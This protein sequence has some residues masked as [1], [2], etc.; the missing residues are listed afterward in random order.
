M[1]FQAAAGISTLHNLRQKL[2]SEAYALWG[3]RRRGEAA[4]YAGLKRC[5]EAEATLREVGV[6]AH[7]WQTAK[8]ALDTAVTAAE[9]SQTAYRNAETRRERLERIRRVAPFLSD[10]RIAQV[11]R[12]HL[13]TPAAL[14]P[15]AAK[16]FD[17]AEAEIA[18]AAV[19]ER[20][21]GNRRQQ[22]ADALAA[23]CR[24]PA[25]IAHKAL[26]TA[27]AGRVTEFVKATNDLPGVQGQV[28]AN[29]ALVRGNARQ[30]GWIET[31]PEAIAAKWSIS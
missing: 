21:L 4:Y 25:L 11:E 31:E 18:R 1:L 7:K 20:L 12:E 6:S 22:Q 26:I 13:G 5:E 14:P 3:E 28:E 27:L 8:R 9:E 19:E 15:D 10:M 2:E 24:R 16:T 30:L 23:L 29:L 17:A